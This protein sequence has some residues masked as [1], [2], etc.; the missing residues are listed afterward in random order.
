MATTVAMPS[1]RQRDDVF[2]AFTR[3]SDSLLPLSVG[4]NFDRDA[5]IT[6]CQDG[7]RAFKV[8]LALLGGSD[9]DASYASSSEE[10]FTGP[11]ASVDSSDGEDSDGEPCGLHGADDS[12][13]DSSDDDDDDGG[14]DDYDPGDSDDDDGG[15][16]SCSDSTSGDE[17]TSSDELVADYAG[18]TDA[19]RH[20]DRCASWGH[21]NQYCPELPARKR[22]R[23]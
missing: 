7:I 11:G 19:S 17:D 16:V 10:S 1:S 4:D 18:L 2:E 23:L 14:A 8:I 13:G 5:A 15:L 3:L 21:T 22:R 12:G 20:C 6:A 9:P